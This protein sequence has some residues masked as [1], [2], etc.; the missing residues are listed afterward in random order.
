MIQKVVFLVTTH[1]I[2][3]HLCVSRRSFNKT[4]TYYILDHSKT[5]QTSLTLCKA[6]LCP[7]E[8]YLSKGHSANLLKSY[9]YIHSKSR[10][11]LTHC[12]HHNVNLF[13]LA[14]FVWKK[15]WWSYHICSNKDHL[16][17]NHPLHLF[18]VKKIAANYPKTQLLAM[19][20]SH[21][22]PKFCLK[23]VILRTLELQHRWYIY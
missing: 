16:S 10:P 18:L 5:L 3:F 15:V 20:I 2:R 11:S 9:S 4:V 14:S 1:W 8:G 21:F 19:K 12:K 7:A 13:I 6:I 23:N 22:L 17:N